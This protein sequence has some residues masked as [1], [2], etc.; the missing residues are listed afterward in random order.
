M[1]CWECLDGG[2]PSRRR[3]EK[4]ASVPEEAAAKASLKHLQWLH[5]SSPS[6]A[7]RTSQS[8]KTI[9]RKVGNRTALRGSMSSAV[10]IRPML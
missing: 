9:K 10:C 1:G 3:Q 4:A 2:A 8:R 6:T 7:N 5:L